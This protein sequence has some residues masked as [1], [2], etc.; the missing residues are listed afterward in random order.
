V[1]KAIRRL[2][3][4]SSHT[5]LFSRISVWD[6]VWGGVSPLAAY[7]LRDGT[8]LRPNGV[9]IYCGIAFFV[10]LLV[11]QWFQTS[12][13]ISRF[14]SIRD[15]FE[16]IKACVLIAAL[17]AALSFVL[18][19]LE[20]APR[21]IP[22]LHFML[23]ASGLLGARLLL[24]LL[25]TRRETGQPGSAAKVD[26]VLII[27]ASR[28]AWFF[29]KMVEELAPGGYQIVAI[30]DE[31]PRLKHR[32][33]NGYPIIGTP[34]ELERVVADYAMHG[35][36][37]DKVVVAAQP[38][39][40][41][42]IAWREVSRVC[43]E[44]HIG[45]E[46]LPERLMV[47][48]AA[49]N[50]ETEIVP[51]L[52]GTTA[53]PDS[54]LPMALDRPFWKIKRAIDFVVALTIAI[55]LSPVIV[56]VFGLALLDVGIPAIFWQQRAGRNG[57]PLHLYK[58]RTLKTL[59][60]RQTKEKRE[61]QKPS[62]IGRFLRKTRLDELPQLWNVLSGEMSLV[63]PR[64]LLPADQP[65]DSTRRLLVRPGVT[66]WAQICGGRLISAEEKS[67]LDEWYIRHASL[68][69]DMAIV[70]R[71]IWILFSG[72]RRDDEAIAVAFLE[73][74]EG[75][76]GHTPISAQAPTTNEKP[77]F[78][79]I[80]NGLESNRRAAPARPEYIPNS[81]GS[82]GVRPAS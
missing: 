20:E 67:A 54:T 32:S 23:L 65:Q 78:L 49:D 19:R 76:L 9:A 52:D 72:D 63:G 33:L 17:S 29:S 18:T 55:L 2:K 43:R 62:V 35:V 46:V 8:I 47:E 30:L 58:F 60:D 28:L 40:L 56:V 42:E 50:D 26:H 68:R 11:F 4:P 24:R 81:D 41:T 57:L 39:D 16:L 69:L 37:I 3:K 27:E 6:V 12:S 77:D 22:I 21:S 48:H 13:P 66:G 53:V 45:L 14:Y 51:H 31:R 7:L 15:A 61:A 1:T 34:S 36:R 59:F 80:P 71:T 75:A 73:Q 79:A 82:V 44:Q 64:P 25:Q 74:S 5:R 38:E 10:S 70:L